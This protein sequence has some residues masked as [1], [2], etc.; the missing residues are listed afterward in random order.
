M[1]RFRAE[2]I[3]YNG[4]IRAFFGPKLRP[5]AASNLQVK[6]PKLKVFTELE[7]IVAFSTVGS[8][9]LVTA[10]ILHKQLPYPLTLLDAL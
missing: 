7:L 10:F 3:V 5:A 4:F 1:L 6:K 2:Q 9:I 8:L